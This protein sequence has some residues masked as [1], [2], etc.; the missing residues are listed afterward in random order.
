MFHWGYLSA[1]LVIRAYMYICH[2]SNRISILHCSERIL[3]FIC[4]WA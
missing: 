1:L 3:L 4:F 2:S